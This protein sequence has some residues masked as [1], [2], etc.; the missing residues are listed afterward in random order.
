MRKQWSIFGFSRGAAWSTK[1]AADPTLKFHRVLLV[2]PYVLPSLSESD[3]GQIAMRLPLYKEDL[4]TCFGSRDHWPPSELI[5][6]IQKT[7]CNKVF[8]GMGHEASKVAGAADWGWLSS[9]VS[10]SEPKV[11]PWT[12]VDISTVDPSLG[13]TPSLPTNSWSSV[14]Q[15][16]QT[17]STDISTVDPTLDATSSLPANS[18]SSIPQP[19]Q[20]LS[21]DVSPREGFLLMGGNFGDPLLPSPLLRPRS[22]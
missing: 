20:N 17:S 2:A 16:K 19:K 12:F 9:T 3:K 21:L 8:E 6:Q 5:Q 14:P 4:M 1:L 15:P 10:V 13:A 11:D 7:C 18:T 22:H